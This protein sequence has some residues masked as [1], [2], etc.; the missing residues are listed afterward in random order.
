MRKEISKRL[1]EQDTVLHIDEAAVKYMGADGYD[2]VYF[3]K[4]QLAVECF[5]STTQ[6][7]ITSF[8]AVD[9]PADD[10]TNPAP[11]TTFAHVHATTVSSLGLAA[12]YI[13][14]SR[15]IRFY[16]STMFQKILLVRLITRLHKPFK[17]ITMIHIIKRFYPLPLQLPLFSSKPSS[18]ASKSSLERQA[19]GFLVKSQL[20]IQIEISEHQLSLRNPHTK[21][22]VLDIF[23]PH[24]QAIESL[25][26]I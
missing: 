20:F 1:R 8:Q 26:S 17:N 9:V 5:T 25:N 18:P 24:V 3:K 15:F 11:A 16:I 14:C 2:C 22:E 6:G 4:I 7:S 10:L 12:R 23:S 21:L 19:N 13:S